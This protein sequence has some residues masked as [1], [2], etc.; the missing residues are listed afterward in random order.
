MKKFAFVSAL[1]VCAITLISL[2]PAQDMP[3][4]DE[5][6]RILPTAK[7]VVPAAV[8]RTPEQM[9]AFDATFAS[10]GQVR[11][12][13]VRPTMDEAQYAAIKQAANLAPRASSRPGASAPDSPLA[14]VN[15]KFV[16]ASE[17]DDP[18]GGFCWIPPDVAGSIGKSQFVSVSN[19]VFQV[20]S[21]GGVL[22]K[23]ETLNAL[24]G[25]SSTAMFD[26]RVQYD[27]E[28]QRW[29][30]TADAF[31]IDSTHQY[32]G[33]AV[34]KTSSAT[35]SWYI[36][37]TNTSSFTG[38]SYFYDF[39]GLGM[40]QDAILFTANIFNPSNN[41]VGS[42]LWSVAKAR[43]YNGF[44]WS[45]PI[46]TGLSGTM[47]TAHQNLTDQ[48]GY[49]WYAAAPGNSGRID[50]VA[51]SF[52]ANPQDTQLFG[53]YNPSGVL[54]FSIPP[55]APQ[56]TGCSNT[57]DTLDNRFQNAGTQ[58]GDVFYQV[59]TVANGS[60]SEPRYY[61]ITGLNS[62]TPV[63]NTVADVF[64]NGSSWDFN[65]SIASD[66]SGRFGLN[67]STTTPAFGFGAGNPGEHFRDN[68]GGSPSGSGG[69][70]VFTSAS[71][72]NTSGG[73][74]YRWG[75][76]SQVSIDPGPGTVS[77]LGTKIFWID[78]ETVPS[79]NFWSTEI[80]KITY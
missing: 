7:L 21:R 48:N 28:Y 57:L 72:Y 34:S 42:D 40:S 63:V 18:Y 74:T 49:A 4:P 36:Y 44:G 43:I 20:R 22:L 24:F 76:Y 29:I 46:F 13:A 11:E 79:V 52:P 47:Q 14:V 77:N 78:N 53:Y 15:T 69:L 6:K 55:S 59:H 62:F 41:F 5:S 1:S 37:F 50:M 26:P 39:P 8:E 70:Y 19:D 66:V 25:Y 67:W 12:A 60:F 30:V 23:H 35:G 10:P 3:K 80:A 38:T 17:C 73:G 71:C 64:A 31:P 51:E 68:N 32:L 16:G 75:D 2:A 58:N 9:A 61:I 56:P 45:V 33:V 54:A 65:P 27:E